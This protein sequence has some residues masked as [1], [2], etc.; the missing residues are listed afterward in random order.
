MPPSSAEV[1]RASRLLTQFKTRESLRQPTSLKRLGSGVEVPEFLNPFLSTAKAANANK[2]SGSRYSLRRQ[3]ELLK[4]AQVLIQSG[5]YD[6]NLVN[7]LPPGPKTTSR[8]SGGGVD[9]ALAALGRADSTVSVAGVTKPVNR[10]EQAPSSAAPEVIWKGVPP[11]R[12][13]IGMYEGRKVAFKRHIWEREHKERQAS[14]KKQVQGM[15]ERIETW[16]NRRAGKTAG[17]KLPF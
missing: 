4:A 16:R 15:D 11:P 9:K 6:K 10:A 17:T 3:K 1:L 12:K 5:D 8:V 13:S 14:I 2:H 7:F